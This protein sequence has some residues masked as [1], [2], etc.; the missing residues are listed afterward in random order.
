VSNTEVPVLHPLFDGTERRERD[1]DTSGAAEGLVHVVVSL[2]PNVRAVLH[3]LAK[4]TEKSKE[5]LVTKLLEYTAP[6]MVATTEADLVGKLTE[7][8]DHAIVQ[9]K[10]ATLTL[11][12]KPEAIFEAL[13]AAQGGNGGR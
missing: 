11:L 10:G 7:L 5:V 13:V 4:E 3:L 6:A 2:P 8:V 1:D 9:R 12:Y